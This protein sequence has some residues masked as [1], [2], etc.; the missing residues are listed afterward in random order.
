MRLV[1]AL[2]RLPVCFREGWITWDEDEEGVGADMCGG[3]DDLL[4]DVVGRDLPFL[5]KGTLI[6]D[7]VV[8]GFLG[9]LEVAVDRVLNLS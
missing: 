8:G 4:R 7:M 9:D 5:K 3:E 2:R 1:P 6:S